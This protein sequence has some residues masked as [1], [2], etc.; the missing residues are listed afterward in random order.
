MMP[1]I[2][3]N[4]DEKEIIKLLPY[5]AY[6]ALEDLIEYLKTGDD[7]HEFSAEHIGVGDLQEAMIIVV[8]AKYLEYNYSLNPG[9]IEKLEKIFSEENRKLAERYG[10][11]EKLTIGMLYTY[12][13]VEFEFFRTQL[14]KYMKEIITE[15]ELYDIFFKRLNLNVFVDYYSIRWENINETQ[16]FLTYLDEE[17]V[18]VGD[19]ARGQKARGMRYKQFSKQEILKREE[20][21]WDANAKKIYEF[22]KNKNDNI[23]EWNFERLLKE[24]EL[25]KVY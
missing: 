14:C 17:V 19:I 2:Y 11:I 16:S 10:E 25:E 18:D 7:I 3:E 13:V 22:L 8:R 6:N 24:N 1:E 9:V 21:L 23:W 20:Y 15:E 4:A 12:G 5:K